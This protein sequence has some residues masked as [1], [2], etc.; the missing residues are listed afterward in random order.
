MKRYIE[1]IFEGSGSM[2][3][4]IKGEPKHKIAKRLYKEKIIL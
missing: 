1:I 2:N 3:E 4:A